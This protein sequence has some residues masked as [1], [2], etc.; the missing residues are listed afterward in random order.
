[1]LTEDDIGLG[2]PF[3]HAVVDHA[4]RPARDFF[5]GLNDF[6]LRRREL[7]GVG[8]HRGKPAQ[9]DEIYIG[10]WMGLN[11][12][13]SVGGRV[14]ENSWMVST[15]RGFGMSFDPDRGRSVI[16][17]RRRAIA[18]IPVPLFGWDRISPSFVHFISLKPHGPYRRLARLFR[19]R[20]A[21]A[22][23]PPPPVP[24]RA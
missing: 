12:M 8:L 22:G 2:K 21:A 4:A 6:Y 9:T 15:W 19:D 14:G 16:R 18:G 3:G 11:G 24:A 23:V 7:L 1:M 5:T 10:L 17:K 13:D 20:L